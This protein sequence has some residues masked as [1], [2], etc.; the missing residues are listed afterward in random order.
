[1]A[2]EQTRITTILT[3]Q[4]AAELFRQSMKVSWWSETITGSGTQFSKP[5]CNAFSELDNDPPSFSVV[6]KL[7]GR[8]AAIQGSAVHMY[9]WDRGDCREIAIVVEK[10]LLAVGLKAKRKI[11]KF[12]SIVQAADLSTKSPNGES[13]TLRDGAV[14]AGMRGTID[15]F[16]S[17]GGSPG[18]A[19]DKHGNWVEVT[20]GG[21]VALE[22][23]TDG[24]SY[25]FGEGQVMSQEGQPTVEHV[26]ILGDLLQQ[27]L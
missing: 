27:L 21:I 3:L 26:D 24:V 6:A 1:M 12:L 9:A 19:T 14:T 10:N 22:V 25:K 8:G 13:A 23:V 2:R 17:S 5:L 20:S 16:W 4:E 18:R 15:A 11:D 7:G